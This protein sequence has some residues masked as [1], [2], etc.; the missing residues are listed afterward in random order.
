MSQV[1]DRLT[2]ISHTLQ[3]HTENPDWSDIRVIDEVCITS[4]VRARRVQEY[5]DILKR[6]KKW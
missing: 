2:R 1:R 4:G 6:C 3:L 5:I